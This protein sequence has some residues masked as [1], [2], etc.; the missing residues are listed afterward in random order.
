ME[1]KPDPNPD[2]PK[3]EMGG[4]HIVITGNIGPGAVIG[5]G[6]VQADYIAGNDLIINGTV[7]ETPER[8]SDLLTDLR[9]IVAQAKEAG[10]L[11]EQVA[12]QIIDNIDEAAEIVKTNPEKPPKSALVKRLE[13]VA[14]MLD[15]AVDVIN[16][17][18]GVAKILLK[19]API[20]A[21]LVKIALR[22][23]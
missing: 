15:A 2:A 20:A 11:G 19:A 17:D 9:S 3:R 6:S 18:G 16:V 13:S 1:N 22:F 4:D 8:F 23:F 7:A 5:S 21:L 10:E 14:D 12:Q